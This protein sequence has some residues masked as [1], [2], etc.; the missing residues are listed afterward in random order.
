MPT[1][2]NVLYVKRKRLLTFC[3]AIF[4]IAQKYLS[5]TFNGSVLLLP[6][7]FIAFGATSFTPAMIAVRSL[8]MLKKQI[9]RFGLFTTKARFHGH[10]Q[11]RKLALARSAFFDLATTPPMRAQ[12]LAL[13]PLS[14]SLLGLGA[15][16]LSLLP[17]AALYF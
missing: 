7:S 14:A 5:P 1:I 12:K 16:G 4:S 11:R 13:R 10:F 6:R 8:F 15:G 17:V 9:K 3:R 2:H